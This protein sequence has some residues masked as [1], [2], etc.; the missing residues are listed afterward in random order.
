MK[1][2][3]VKPRTEVVRMEQDAILAQ[4]SLQVVQSNLQDEQEFEQ[5]GLQRDADG[6]LW[7][8]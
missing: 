1:K 4:A 8:D 7:G 2:K 3:Y 5:T 6:F